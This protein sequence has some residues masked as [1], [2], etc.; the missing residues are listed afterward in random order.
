VSN[1]AAFQCPQNPGRRS[2][3]SLNQALSGRSANRV[4]P[5]TVLLFESDADWNSAGGKSSLVTHKHKPFAT[6][7]GSYPNYSTSYPNEDGFIIVHVDGSAEIVPRSQLS[8][9]RWDP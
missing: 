8:R 5:T 3:F 4:N 9:L 7:S 1:P 2:S 6:Y